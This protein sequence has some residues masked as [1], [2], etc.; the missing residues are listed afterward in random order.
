MSKIVF[1]GEPDLIYDCDFS[2][3]GENQVR[4]V[5]LNV[6][7]NDEILLSGFNLVNEY[8]GLIQTECEDYIYLY[9]T[10]EDN[11]IVELSNDS[12]TWESPKATVKFI[13][14]SGGELIGITE[15]E[16]SD[17]EELI[18][19][20]VNVE[21]GCEFIKWT[22]QIPSDG[23]I[24]EG[25]LYIYNAV[26]VD[27]NIYFYACG[28]GFLEGKTKQFASDYSELKIPTP[29]ACENYCFSCWS[30]EIP[31]SGDIDLDKTVFYAIFDNN[32]SERLKTVEGDVTSTQLALTE[33]FETT[34]D[35]A[36]QLT[37]VQLALTEIYEQ[38]LSV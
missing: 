10:Y 15:Q 1:I 31:T 19:P 34:I 29:V 33:V 25:G 2:K 26:I 37:D 13:C 6:I 17:Y 28:N 30:P 38:V 20:T 9:R 7:P 36:Q 22:P 11:K 5:F 23:K 24:Q 12:S 35:N 16:I 18:I 4:I 27:K 21:E 14:E 32:I 8:N 3:I